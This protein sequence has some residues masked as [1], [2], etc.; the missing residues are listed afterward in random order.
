MA[1]QAIVHKFWMGSKGWQVIDLSAATKREAKQ[2]ADAYCHRMSDTFCHYSAYV[3]EV[4][5]AA[6]QQG[7][8]EGER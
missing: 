7:G 1:F 6:L 4:N 2:E 5:V 8:G 3:I